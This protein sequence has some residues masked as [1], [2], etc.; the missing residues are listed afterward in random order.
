MIR[1]IDAALP[2]VAQKLSSQESPPDEG[3]FERELAQ[4]V[5]RKL[6]DGAVLTTQ[7]EI[8]LRGWPG[9]GPVDMTLRVPG[10][11]PFLVELKW[12]AGSLYN[13]AWD[14][15][16][17][18]TA[19]AEGVTVATADL[20]AG[21]PQASWEKGELGAELFAET[22]DWDTREFLERH[23]ENFAYWRGEVN[24]RPRLVPER[25]SVDVAEDASFPLQI[26]GVEW[27]IRSA[28]VTLTLKCAWLA[29]DEDGQI[30]SVPADLPFPRM[31]W[32]NR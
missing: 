4:R 8:K 10:W 23:A 20:I 22:E 19:L 16:K 6:P 17:L 29:I 7:D 31:Q 3:D 11:Q 15:L 28:A 24:T 12:G 25:F 2:G 21:A 1:A 30:G 18:A 27:E 13:C 32:E 5:R 9:V 26:D 14:A